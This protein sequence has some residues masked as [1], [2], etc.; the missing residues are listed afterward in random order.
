MFLR[1]GQSGYVLKPAPLLAKEYNEDSIL[2]RSRYRFNVKIISGQQIPR[3]RDRE[4]H[5]RSSI[6]KN[7]VDP[8]VQMF[9]HIPDWP[10]KGKVA[11]TPNDWAAG[12]EREPV[13]GPE[14]SPGKSLRHLSLERQRSN[15]ATSKNVPASNNTVQA[16]TGAV[17]NNGFDPKWQ[18]TLSVEFE[19]AND[20]L[21]LVF[22]QLVVKDETVNDDEHSLAM[23]CIPLACLKPGM[24]I[25][26]LDEYY[27][28]TLDS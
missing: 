1:N 23:Y 5:G 27:H 24:H 19:V 11:S 15:K 6:D 18:E 4:Q 26:D 8:Y 12:P 14:A 7:T 9:V 25:F 13:Y 22:V 20:M 21:D 2:R 16:R 17:K 28:L 3:R 10:D